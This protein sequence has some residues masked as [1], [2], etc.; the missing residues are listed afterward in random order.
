MA[1]AVSFSMTDPSGECGEFVFDEK[2]F[3]CL[4]GDLA[5]IGDVCGPILMMLSLDILV[6]PLT[7]T[8]CCY[9]SICKAKETT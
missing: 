8:P 7:P 3:K 2:Q 1:A 4:N 9:L 5:E 6:N